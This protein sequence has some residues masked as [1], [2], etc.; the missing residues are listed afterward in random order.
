MQNED[1]K[2]NNLLKIN[3]SKTVC[4]WSL[5]MKALLLYI[6]I[7][8]TKDFCS[9]KNFEFYNFVLCYKKTQMDQNISLNS[10]FD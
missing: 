9:M 5:K 2:E 7:L 3:W 10:L 4:F 8:K 6:G 1:Q